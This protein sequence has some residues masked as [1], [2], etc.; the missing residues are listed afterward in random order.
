MRDPH[1]SNAPY[2]SILICNVIFSILSINLL[3]NIYHNVINAQSLTL[4]QYLNS[5]FTPESNDSELLIHLPINLTVEST[6]VTLPPE[7][8]IN[9]TETV[10]LE[11]VTLESSTLQPSH[12]GMDMEFVCDN[13]QHCP[14]H[15]SCVDSFCKCIPGFCTNNATCLLATSNEV[16]CLCQSGFSGKQCQFKDDL[17][18][19]LVCQNGGICDPQSNHTKCICPQSECLN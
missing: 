11:T 15:S 1:L 4:P 17:C 9:H 6:I 2:R 18:G 8:I 10:P 14:A 19:I 16:V 7:D 3:V 5:S 12:Y 13:H